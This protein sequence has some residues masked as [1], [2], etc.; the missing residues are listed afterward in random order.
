MLKGTLQCVFPQTKKNIKIQN[1]N[2]QIQQKYEHYET[3]N[4]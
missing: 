1:N 4:I 2:R 3:V